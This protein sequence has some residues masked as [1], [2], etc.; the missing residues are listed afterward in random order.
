MSYAAINKAVTRLSAG[1][2]V[3]MS[4]STTY[5]ASWNHTCVVYGIVY[6]NGTSPVSTGVFNCHMGWHN[7]HNGY[8]PA[9]LRNLIL[10]CSWFY[11]CGYIN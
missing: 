1:Y 8:T 9:N 5:S 6:E 11:E 2:P 7:P 4:M 10:A 3:I